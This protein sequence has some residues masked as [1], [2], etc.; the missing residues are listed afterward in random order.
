MG[1]SSKENSRPSGNSPWNSILSPIDSGTSTS[2]LSNPEGRVFQASRDLWP[3]GGGLLEIYSRQRELGIALLRGQWR[4]SVQEGFAVS[5]DSAGAGS[6]Q[7]VE[8]SLIPG[9]I[10]SRLRRNFAEGVSHVPDTAHSQA[11]G[12][13]RNERRVKTVSGL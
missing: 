9:A 5:E 12:P 3:R 6:E 1:S 13:S 11:K 2:S 4:R 7:G 10:V 8:S